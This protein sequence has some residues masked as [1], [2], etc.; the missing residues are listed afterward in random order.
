MTEE[1]ALT[2]RC[3]GPMP[4]GKHLHQTPPERS[5]VGSKCMA[6]QITPELVEQ[7]FGKIIRPK[8]GFCGL[9]VKPQ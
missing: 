7:G 8:G 6:W 1:E 3:C 4:C 2:K 5:C 9:A